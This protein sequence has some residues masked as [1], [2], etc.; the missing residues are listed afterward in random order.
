MKSMNEEERTL[1]DFWHKCLIYRTIFFIVVFDISLYTV[2]TYHS[3][4]QIK[5]Y[6]NIELQ[7]QNLYILNEYKMC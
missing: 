6:N 1:L 3:K 7:T 4:K 2:N 5:W